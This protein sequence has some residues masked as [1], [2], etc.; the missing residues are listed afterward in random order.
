MY[1]SNQAPVAAA[2]DAD[3]WFMARRCYL[4]GPSLPQQRSA[5]IRNSSGLPGIPFR[6]SFPPSH[7]GNVLGC[8]ATLKPPA[9]G[10]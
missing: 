5:S 3:V 8:L 6:S 9:N 4:L 7:P 10:G 2:G 1:G